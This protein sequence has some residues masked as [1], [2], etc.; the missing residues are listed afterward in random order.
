MI[1]PQKLK[2][3][4][5]FIAALILTWL[6]LSLL[7]QGCEWLPKN[8]GASP[9]SLSTPSSTPSTLASPSTKPWPNSGW[10]PEYEA[11][12]KN[13][14]PPLV[15][16]MSNVCPKW[17]TIDRTKA[18]V[19]LWKGIIEAESD[20]NRTARY[21]ENTL[22]IDPV[23]GLNVVSEGLLQLSYADVPNYKLPEC[24][25]ISWAKDRLLKPTDPNK[26]IFDP[27]LNLQCAMAIAKKEIERHPDGG[28]YGTGLG[29]YWSTARP[30]KPGIKRFLALTPECL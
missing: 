4:A 23:T 27:I 6:L 18:W 16:G 3:G 15:Y 8:P 24:A 9:S 20:F 1:E 13:S 7:F 2:H 22:G 28:K 19:N 11:I 21:T 10:L 26:T 30:G 17:W 5:I 14:L 12:V 29:Y 25:G